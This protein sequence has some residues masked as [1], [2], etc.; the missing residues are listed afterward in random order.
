MSLKS[1]DKFCENLI[2]KEPEQ[3][4]NLLDERQK[5]VRSRIA[6]EALVIFA[7]LSIANCILMDNFRKWAE[8]YAPTLLIFGMLCGIYFHIRCFTKDC[9]FGIDGAKPARMTSITMVLISAINCARFLF[10]DERAVADSGMLTEEF[11]FFLFWCIA[12][13]GGAI[14]LI[15]IGAY[16]RKQKE[17]RNEP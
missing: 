7:V 9:L 6:A 15:N 5:I 2:L 14:S 16:E 11:M 3:E 10:K 17:E 4:Q 8:S 1:F 12:A 13:I